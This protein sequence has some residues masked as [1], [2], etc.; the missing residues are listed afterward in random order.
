RRRRRARRPAPGDARRPG[1]RIRAHRGRAG[2]PAAPLHPAAARIGAGPAAGAPRPRPGGTAPGGAGGPRPEQVLRPGQGS[3]PDRRRTGRRIPAA[4]RPDPGRRRR[5]RRRQVDPAAPAH[6]AGAAGPRHRAAGRRADRPG[7]RRGRRVHPPRPAGLPEPGR[8]PEPVAAHRPR[9]RRTPGGAPDR[10]RRLPRPARPGPAGTGRP[11]RRRRRPAPVPAL[12]RPAAAGG[13]RPRPGARTRR[14]GARRTGVRDGPGGAVR[15]PAAAHRAAGPARPRLPAG[16]ARPGRGPR[17]RPRGA[18]PAPRPR[19]RA[20]PHRRAVHRPEEPAHPG[21]AGGRA[22]TAH[23]PDPH[24][25]REDD[26]PV[27]P[28]TRTGL[29]AAPA[30]AALLLTG[31]AGG[32][33]AAADGSDPAHL[34]VAYGWYPTCLDYAQ[35]NPFALFGRQVLDTLLSENPDSGELEPYLAES[36]EVSDGGRTYEFTIREGVTFSN[37]EELTA[38]V[39]ADNFEKLWELAEQGAA[40]TPGAYLR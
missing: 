6:P 24:A 21:T 37:G 1:R 12:R 36:W 19:R 5:V 30:A 27:T 33:G 14:G 13:D 17:R 28:S 9:R 39:V 23:P 26:P 4:P 11:A 8:Q 3:R 20:R 25:E 32:G 22:G 16:L 38:R 34:R 40:T 2:R 10:H 31:C 15:A 35:S 29:I 18:G 7:P